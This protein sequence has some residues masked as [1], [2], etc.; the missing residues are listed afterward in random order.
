MDDKHYITSGPYQAGAKE[1]SEDV[2]V[3]EED[4]IFD[5][6]SGEAYDPALLEVDYIPGLVTNSII[7]C[8]H[9]T[10]KDH[11]CRKSVMYLQLEN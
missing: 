3:K 8:W 4:E 7:F 10:I 5:D 6:D 2:W 11:H 1:E 9:F